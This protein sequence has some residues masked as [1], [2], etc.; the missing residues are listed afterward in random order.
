LSAAFR[1]RKLGDVPVRSPGRMAD[2]A[3]DGDPGFA[4]RALDAAIKIGLVGLLAIWCLEIVRPFML[5]LIWGAII[6]IASYPGF[7][8]L[9]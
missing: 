9:E 7:V 1:R 5:P 6:A 8:R 4:G 3:G 2:M